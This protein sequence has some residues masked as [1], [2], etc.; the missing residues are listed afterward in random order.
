MEDLNS[1]IVVDRFVVE[2]TED[3]VEEVFE[4]EIVV[5]EISVILVRFVDRGRVFIGSIRFQ[6]V[7]S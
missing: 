4:E 6:N 2:T 1:V 7:N 5:A 3:A